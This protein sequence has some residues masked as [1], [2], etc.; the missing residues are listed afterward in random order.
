[1][2]AWWPGLSALGGRDPQQAAGPGQDDLELSPL[3]AAHAKGTAGRREPDVGSEEA[4][5]PDDDPGAGVGGL[6]GGTRPA[7]HLHGVKHQQA[8]PARVAPDRVIPIDEQRSALAEA[9]VVTADVEVHKTVTL[10]GRQV[11]SEEHT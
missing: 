7:F 11:R 1:M 10:G 8:I 6:G 5:D 4:G 3:E 2:A 9:D